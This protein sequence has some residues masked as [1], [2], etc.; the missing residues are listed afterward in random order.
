MI[1]FLVPFPRGCTPCASRRSILWPHLRTRCPFVWTRVSSYR[2]LPCA[3]SETQV[4]TRC[5]EYPGV[6][7]C[8]RPLRHWRSREGLR[9]QVHYRFWLWDGSLFSCTI[10]HSFRHFLQSAVWTEKIVLA[11]SCDCWC[12]TDGEDDSTHHVWN[13]LSWAC[14]RVGVWCLCIWFGSLGP[15]WHRQIT[16]RAQ[17]CGFLKHVS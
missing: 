5:T 11:L 6:V 12:G 9:N 3:C 14:L 8:I 1:W 16:N 2:F 4:L 17:L 7:W 10:L 13:Y 15:D